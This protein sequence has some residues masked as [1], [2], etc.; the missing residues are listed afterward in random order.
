[1]ATVIWISAGVVWLIGFVLIRAM[2]LRYLSVGATMPG[3]DIWS[4]L[5][6]PLRL[7]YGV[8]GVA[9]AALMGLGMLLFPPKTPD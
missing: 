9:G 1:M 3:L 2:Q 4:A 8:F 6:W 7:I 5:L